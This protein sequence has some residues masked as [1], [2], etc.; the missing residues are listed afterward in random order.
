MTAID[1]CKVAHVSNLSRMETDNCSESRK[2]VGVCNT[3]EHNEKPILW[4]SNL[5]NGYCH[6]FHT[7]AAADEPVDSTTIVCEAE[8][9]ATCS[10]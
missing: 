9:F 10:V 3:V 7:A 2:K 8:G 5:Y 6:S 4:W 1:F